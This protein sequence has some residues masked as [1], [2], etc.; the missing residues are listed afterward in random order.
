[1]PIIRLYAA[2]GNHRIHPCVFA[3][4]SNLSKPIN[5]RDVPPVPDRER[6]LL[7]HNR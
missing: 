1:M 7:D 5:L 2:I 6:H 3:M 4:P